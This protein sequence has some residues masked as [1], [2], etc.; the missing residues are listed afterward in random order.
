M[1]N[2]EEMNRNLESWAHGASIF[3]AVVCPILLIIMGIAMIY[4]SYKQKQIN[5]PNKITFLTGI[6]LILLSMIVPFYILWIGG[7]I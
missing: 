5:R 4:L 6:L 7:I 1:G 2:N 3:G